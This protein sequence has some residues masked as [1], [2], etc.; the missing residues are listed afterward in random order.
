MQSALAKKYGSLS[1]SVASFP[2]PFTCLGICSMF[3]SMGIPCPQSHNPA[4]FVVQRIAIP[5]DHREEATQAVESL[6]LHYEASAL[7]QSNQAWRRTLPV[8]QAKRT[9]VFSREYSAP[10]LTQFRHNLVRRFK[11]DM[12]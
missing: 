11:A 4:D 9:Q 12:R 2:P 7:A 6:I 5:A 8:H 10:F 1:I 3:R